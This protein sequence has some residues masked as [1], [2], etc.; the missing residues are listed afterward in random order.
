MIDPRK[1][2]ER[3]LKDIVP[4]RD[5]LSQIMECGKDEEELLK[6]AVYRISY[7]KIWGKKAERLR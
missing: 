7:D 4:V 1:M 3:G 6:N 5:K 2:R